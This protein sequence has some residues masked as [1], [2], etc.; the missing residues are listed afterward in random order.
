MNQA[1]STKNQAPAATPL[2]FVYGTLRRGGSNHFRMDGMDL[3]SSATVR[4]RLYRVEWF[5]ALVL[6]PDAPEVSGEIY[7][8]NDTSLSALDEYEGAQYH[9]VL[10]T[11]TA[12]DAQGQ[13]HKVWIWEW[14]DSIDTL[15]P[16]AGGDWLHAG[17]ASL[18]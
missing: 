11:A 18:T 2:I 6:D 15:Q 8:I 3:I 7:Q 1:P 16:I 17:G 10:T 14:I 13:E 4:G 9:R 5:P 12:T